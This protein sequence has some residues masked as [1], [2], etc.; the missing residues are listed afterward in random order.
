MDKREVDGQNTFLASEYLEGVEFNLDD[1]RYS[2]AVGI[3][4]ANS[5]DARI[6]LRSEPSTSSSLRG[7]GLVGDVVQL[8]DAEWSYY[9]WSERELGNDWQ[10]YN[11]IP[12]WYYVQFPS[13]RAEGWIRS[14]YIKIQKAIPSVKDLEIKSSLARLTQNQIKSLL[15]LD[16][17]NMHKLD[18]RIIIPGYLPAGYEVVEFEIGE[19][20]LGPGYSITYR[21]SVGRDI[22]LYAR[23]SMNGK[24]ADV[25]KVEFIPIQS[26]A[27]GNVTAVYMSYDTDL[28]GSSIDVE[29]KGIIAAPQ[30]YEIY[31]TN[32][33]VEDF[34][35]VV[36][37]L[38]YLNP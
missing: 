11:S 38:I 12:A 8:Q 35:K 16:Q 26:K 14:D 3:L 17:N 22:R 13:S 21:N 7:Y 32:P 28:S 6:N 33:N 23:S 5:L 36:E 25:A 20:A 30:I 27:L 29:A 37:N 9:M 34:V 15:L 19:N 4:T 24:G 18:V 1:L 31:S 2:P 10:P